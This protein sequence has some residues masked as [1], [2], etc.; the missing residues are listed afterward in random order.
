MKVVVLDKGMSEIAAVNNVMPQAIVQICKFHVLSL[1]VDS[2]TKD[3][4]V[5]LGVWSLQRQN[6]LLKK[7]MRNL[8]CLLQTHL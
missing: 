1:A 8:L 5:H 6:C 3:K 4:I 2:V 7:L